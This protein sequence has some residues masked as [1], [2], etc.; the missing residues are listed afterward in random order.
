MRRRGFIWYLYLYYLLVI[1]VMAAA[2]SWYSSRSVSRFYMRNTKSDLESTARLVERLVSPAV[3]DDGAIDTGIF[4]SELETLSEMRVT[5]M[6]MNGRVLCDTEE[7]PE[8]MENHRDRPEIA[9]AFAGLTGESIRYS[10]TI[11][12][13]FMYVAVPLKKERRIVGAVRVSVPLTFI[14]RSLRG[15]RARI[16]VGGLM[17]ALLAAI[18]SLFLSRRISIPIRAMKRGIERF[19]RNDLEHRIPTSRIEELGSL[20]DVMNEMAASLAERMNMVTRQRNEQ[21]AIFRSMVEGLLVVDTE[22]RITKINRAAAE[23]LDLDQP[24]APGR[25]IQEAVRNTELQLFV[26][27]ALVSEE[28]VEADIRIIGEAG[29]RMLRAHGSLLLDSQGTRM[30]AVVVLDDV[31]NLRRLEGVRKD[32]VANVSHELRTPITSIKGFVETLMDGGIESHEEANNFLSI[33]AKQADRMNSI[34]EDLLFLSRVEQDVEDDKIHLEECPLCDVLQEAVDICAPKAKAKNIDVELA[35]PD[36]LAAM[37]NPA[38][39]RQAMTNLIDNAITYS[40]AGSLVEVAAES[41][42]NGIVITVT[43]HGCGIE[44]I[45]L[46]R[47]FERFYR[48]GKARSRKVGGTGLGLA[49]VKH[50]VQAHGGRVTVESVPG[51]GSLFSIHLLRA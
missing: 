36:D 13:R 29:E 23:F 2:I 42:K 51:E 12:Q 44:K 45:H 43:D 33:I 32:F 21:E 5:V 17:A 38:L 30:G 18:V 37:I 8:R 35:C 47:I 19:S 34:I 14:D 24:Q 9:Q 46:P 28:P 40:E 48:V 25:T 1:L 41:E 27:R 11:K 49:I 7:D 6:A 39:L 15:I 50:I 16:F 26:T 4:C 31:T 20:A 10:D 22:E 3:M